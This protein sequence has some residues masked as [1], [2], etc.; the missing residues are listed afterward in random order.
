MKDKHFKTRKVIN[1][2]KII[3]T[4]TPP[5]EM[6]G[7]HIDFDEELGWANACICGNRRFKE[8]G[9]KDAI[10]IIKEY[11]NGDDNELKELKKHFKKEFVKHCIQGYSQGDYTYLYIPKKND[12]NFNIKYIEAIYFGAYEEYYNEEYGA[13]AI[14]DDIAWKGSEDIKKEIAKNCGLDAKDIVLKKF[15]DYQKVAQYEEV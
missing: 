4:Q 5:M 7:D 12:K 2:E 6:F 10:D 1:M 13:I 8:Y 15:V 11:Q 3:F 14:I 9:D